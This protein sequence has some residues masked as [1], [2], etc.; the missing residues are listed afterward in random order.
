MNPAVE[1]PQVWQLSVERYHQMVEA[2]IITDD[3]PVELLQGRLIT[4][5]SKKPPHRLSTRL[6]RK[7]LEG[8]VPEGWYV[9]SQEPLTT[10]D[11][12]PEPDISIVRG[13]D[14]DYQLGYFILVGKPQRG[15]LSES[16]PERSRDTFCGTAPHTKIKWTRYYGERHPFPNEIGLVVEVADSTLKSRPWP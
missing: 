11:S 9:D 1:E 3:D 16:R 14:R 10:A 7:A 4:K 8:L 2:G 12:E 5:M 13:S 15:F 6:L